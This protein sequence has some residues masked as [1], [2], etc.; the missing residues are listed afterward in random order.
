MHQNF[1]AQ[2]LQ[3]KLAKRK[4]PNAFLQAAQETAEAHQPERAR[5]VFLGQLNH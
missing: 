4:K 5:R 2:R 3:S 1:A